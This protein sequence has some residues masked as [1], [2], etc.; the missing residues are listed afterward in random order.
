MTTNRLIVHEF[1]RRFCAL[2]FLFGLSLEVLGQDV[3]RTLKYFGST[4]VDGINPV[5][6]VI[7]DTNGV[8]YGS[9][10][11]GGTNGQGTIFKVNKDGSNYRVLKSFAG[12][13]DGANPVAGLLL[14]SDG[15]LYGTTSWDHESGGIVS[16]YGTVFKINPDGGGFK[17]LHHFANGSDGANPL[18]GTLIQA[19]NGFL[20]GTTMNGGGSSQG[21]IFRIGL[22]GSNYLV[23]KRFGGGSEGYH[24]YGGLIQAADGRL[25]G[26]TSTGGAGSRGTIFA[27]DLD[28]TEFTVLHS[29]SGADG[30][31]PYASLIEGR[32]HA[33]YG[34]T[35]DGGDTGDGVVFK[36]N[37]DG[38]GYTV[39]KSLDMNSG[40]RPL[41]P[42]IQGSSGVLYGTS[43]FRGNTNVLLGA[44][45]VFQLNAD[46]SN[47]RVLKV[48]TQTGEG[49]NP[50]AGLLQG[51]DGTLYGTAWGGGPG[52]LAGTVFSL[53]PAA[54][55]WASVSGQQVELSIAGLANCSYTIQRSSAL[56]QQ[57]INLGAVTTDSNGIGRFIDTTPPVSS[58]LYRTA[59]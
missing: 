56:N 5:A 3:F 32:D 59:Q 42:L 31:I 8:L 53:L 21:V 46:G 43:S 45:T 48:F 58:A 33:L 25:Y 15:V 34:T 36:L 16:G 39:L 26:T 19:T 44:G 51:V 20:Y 50:H 23:I 29:L 49:N 47:F 38:S 18:Y 2:A 14:G 30:G 4:S 9:T 28:G 27:I 40:V 57:W 54:G 17:V 52:G 24:P 11:S 37:V 12:T 22:D 41:A 35:A 10:Q 7:M 1:H 55:V 13:G 6:P